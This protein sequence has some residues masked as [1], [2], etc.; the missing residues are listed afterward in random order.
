MQVCSPT[1][2]YSADE[3]LQ[4][5]IMVCICVGWFYAFAGLVE[6]ANGRRNLSEEMPR[7]RYGR[8]NNRD[9]LLR[10]ARGVSGNQVQEPS[11]DRD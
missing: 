5:V 10:R 4:L 8:N 9:G 2:Y 6:T 7:E 1:L 3:T 11:R